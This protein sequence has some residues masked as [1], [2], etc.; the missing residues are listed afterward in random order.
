MLDRRAG[1]K[2][3]VMSS[4][5]VTR[6]CQALPDRAWQGT[7]SMGIAELEVEGGTDGHWGFGR[8]EH[9]AFVAMTSSVS[10]GQFQNSPLRECF[11]RR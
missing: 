3:P 8:S 2:S 1:S 5:L 6:C 7:I 10:P 11:S 9:Q 4:T